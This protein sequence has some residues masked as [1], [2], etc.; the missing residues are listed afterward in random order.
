MQPLPRHAVNSRIFDRHLRILRWLAIGIALVGT[1]GSLIAQSVAEPRWT[2]SA[3][4]LRPFWQGDVMEGESVL[5][6]QDEKTGEARAS[7][8]FPVQNILSVRS[9]SGDV[10]YEE[11]R[12]YTWKAGSREIVVTPGSRIVTSKPEALRRPA[13][14]QQYQLTHRDGNGE[15][16]FGGKLEYH[17]LQTI[18]SYSHA[19]GL[20][21]TSVPKFDPQALPKTIRKLESRAPLKIVIL[22]DSISTGC[23]ASGWADGKPYQPAYPDLV[24]RMLEEHYKGKVEVVNLSVGGMDSA[25]GLTMVDKVVEAS[26]DLVLLAFGMNDSSGRPAKDFQD[27]IA[28]TMKG[29]REK[30]PEAEFVL[31]ATMVGNPGW[32]ALKQQLFPQ[33]RDAL[34]ALCGP[35]AALADVT[36]IWGEFLK[37]KNDW[38]QTGN[39]VNHPNDFGHRVYAQ[40]ISSLLIP[41]SEPA[42]GK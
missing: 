33:Y 38:D 19:P 26:P 31:I 9:S 36:S 6:I 17:D 1:Q 15:I 40:V 7:V 30:R 34:A 11:G 23:N 42:K 27:K 32:V 13:K 37:L 18:V 3:K 29:I 12:D 14:S 41:G 10:K 21:K 28:A 25:W 39:G 5:F 24:G 22:G 20:W 4:M 2:Y 8:L 35:G 16:Y